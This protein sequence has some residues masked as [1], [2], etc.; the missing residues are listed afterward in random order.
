MESPA[1]WTWVW[2]NSRSWWW[3]N[4][5]AWRA[6][7]HGMAKSRTWLSNWTELNWK[8]PLVAQ[9]LKNLLAMRKTQFDPWVRKIPCRREWLPTPVFLPGEFHGQRRLASYSPQGQIESDMTEW[10]TLSK[11]SQGYKRF[12]RET[13]CYYCFSACLVVNQLFI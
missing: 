10:L 11:Q 8:Y 9:M 13:V 2:V 12:T 5:E 7:V 4:R 1:Q 6:A 3:T